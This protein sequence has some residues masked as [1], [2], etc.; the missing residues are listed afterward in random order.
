M[1]P[2][3]SSML[4]VTAAAAMLSAV[5]ADAAWAAATDPLVATSNTGGLASTALTALL[6]GSGQAWLQVRQWVDGGFA[7]APALMLGL[8]V[9]LA[10]PPLALAG[11]LV[12]RTRRSPD[13]TTLIS[14]TSRRS[15]GTSPQSTTRTEISAWP[16]EAWVEVEGR[17][18]G[19]CVI[20]RTLVRIGRE[21]DNEICISARTVHRYHAVIR[22]TTEGEVVINDLSGDDGNGVLVNGTR[23]AEARLTKGDVI[24]VGE[25]KLRFEA[26]PV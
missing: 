17:P 20:G 2:T 23:V 22:R 4:G 15:A 26:R 18:D 11:L 8:S 25:V 19:R 7:R 16:T 12:R 6:D 9:L 1:R 5:S 13:A 14:R 21:G 24:N 10:V 3:G